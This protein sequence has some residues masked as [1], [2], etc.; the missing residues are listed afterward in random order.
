M[1]YFSCDAVERDFVDKKLR[2]SEIKLFILKV[3][4]RSVVSINQ[5]K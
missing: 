5:F 3:L 2:F 4:S 1:Q